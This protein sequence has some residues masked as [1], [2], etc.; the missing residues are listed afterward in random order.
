MP[1]M[2]Y[3]CINGVW[4]VWAN[5]CVYIMR[6]TIWPNVRMIVADTI[7]FD[8]VMICVYISISHILSLFVSLSR[9]PIATPYRYI[10]IQAKS[11]KMTLFD[12]HAFKR[13]RQ[14]HD[15]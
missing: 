11:P 15:T 2:H 13:H 6:A 14:V 7:E 4:L 1:D 10:C 9:M 5:M 8:S 3:L 12:R